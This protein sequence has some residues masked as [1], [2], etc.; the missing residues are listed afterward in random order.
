MDQKDDLEPR[1]FDGC[2]F[3]LGIHLIKFVTA[4]FTMPHL[5]PYNLA[6]DYQSECRNIANSIVDVVL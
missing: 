4:D 6:Q 3:V 1:E 2:R 5:Q